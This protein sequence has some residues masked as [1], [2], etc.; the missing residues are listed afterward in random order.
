VP[1]RDHAQTGAKY[2]VFG[3]SL[4]LV[5]LTVLTRWALV[6]SADCVNAD[7]AV[8]LL[9]GRHFAAGDVT[10]FF[11]GQRYMGAIEPALLMPLG[12][13]GLV[14]PLAGAL[15]TL[16]FALLQ[17]WQVTRLARRIGAPWFV[18]G[19]LFAFAPAVPAVAQMSLNGARHACI[20]L[21]LWAFER[22][23]SSQKNAARTWLGNGV[24]LGIAFFGDHLTL[25]YAP[26]LAYLAWKNQQLRPLLAGFLPILAAD[27]TLA[28]L[29][30]EGRHSL[31]QD[32]RNWLRGVRLFFGSA[33]LRYLGI[34]WLDPASHVAAGWFW[35]LGSLAAAAALALASFLLRQRLRG[36]GVAQLPVRMLLVTAALVAAL[37]MAGALDEESSRYLLLGIT[38]FSLL[39]AWALAARPVVVSVAVVLG[40]L[41]PRIPSAVRLH[42]QASER[43]EACAA[44]M[45]DLI[46]VLHRMQVR[47]VWADYWDAYPLALESHEAWP[48]GLALRVNRRPCW[49]HR[50]RRQGPVAYVVPS[51]RHPLYARVRAAAPEAEWVSIGER[52]IA[53]VPRA[54]PGLD[55]R[56]PRG[57]PAAC[58]R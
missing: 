58:T 16:A 7:S 32:P 45:A 17:L 41:L 42:T 22:A 46:A 54:L 13:V 49:T 53:R 20:S 8:V 47:A 36:S 10:P 15:F 18:A 12:W 51:T 9:M 34:E 6:V 26:P 48:I 2:R 57:A 33:L 50:A 40:L 3:A 37:H 39:V 44:N 25:A 31:P 4:L 38:P 43:G 19:L 27:L 1:A 21:V 11:W 56:E 24:I 5:A 52:R 55:G 28:S 23:I 14:T 35:K 29:S 30:A